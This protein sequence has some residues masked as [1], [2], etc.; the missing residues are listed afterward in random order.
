MNSIDNTFTQHHRHFS[1][2]PF[3]CNHEILEFGFSFDF[4]ILMNLQNTPIT[5]NL[6]NL[7]YIK[8]IFK[9]S[10]QHIFNA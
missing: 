3:K 5:I 9:I 4:F 7:K 2:K 1:I 8:I 10:K 6:K